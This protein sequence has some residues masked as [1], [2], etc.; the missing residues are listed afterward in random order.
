M[1][2]SPQEIEIKLAVAGAAEARKLLYPAGFRIYKR[3][4]FEDNLVLD[5]PNLDLRKRAE[6]LRVREASGKTVVTYKGRPILGR[7]KSR[8]ELEYEA[9][10]ARA[11]AVVFER[12][13][14][15]QVFRY[16][17]Y[18]TEYKQR[19]SKGIA[20]LDETPIGTYLELEGSP[21][22]IDR[23]AAK[24]GFAE[25]D[26]ITASYGRLYLDWAKR[27]RRRPTNMVF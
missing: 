1:S 7:Y 21:K 12:L 22:W 3:R 20:T 25:H 2:G 11:V 27:H 15:Q 17:K 23:T 9:S 18:R 6:L 13:G 19:G 16:Q 4:T 14:F 5:S 8:E 10:S 24:L 26:Y